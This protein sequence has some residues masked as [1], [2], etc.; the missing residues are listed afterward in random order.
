MIAETAE[1]AVVLK[2]KDQLTG[3][4]TAAE[5][6]LGMLESTASRTATGGLSRLQ[7][8]A[9]GV[10]G[11]LG[12]AKSQLGGLITNLGLFGG[13]A[14]LA[15]IGALVTGSVTKVEAL[16]QA[17]MRLQQVTGESALAT[18]S[19]LAVGEK[20]GVS[21]DSLTGIAQM[22]EKTVGK[23][24]ETQATATKAQKS[25][26]LQALETRKLDIQAAGEKTTLI[27]KLITEQKAQD[28]LAASHGGVVAS[29][30][31]LMAMQ[32][33]FGVVLTDSKGQ[34]IGFTQ[35]LT[36]VSAFYAQATTAAQKAVAADLAASVFGKGYKTLL[37]LLVL[38]KQGFAE[39]TAEAQKFGLTL[40][41][42][43][44]TQFKQLLAVQHTWGDVFGGLQIQAG[45]TIIP[46]LTQIGEA[47]NTFLSDPTN[48]ASLIGALK[49]VEQF[50]EQVGGAFTNV[51]IPA[52]QE[53]GGV[54]NSLP[55]PIKELLIGGFLANK[56]VKWTFGIDIAGLATKALGGAVAGLIGNI[57][58]N[59]TTGVMS[60]EA[61]V[62]NVG[63][64][65]AL[66]AG[67]E[68]A[69]L[70]AAEG[71]AGAGIVGGGLL[72]TIAGVVIPAAAV[73]ALAYFADDIQKFL[74]DN[75]T[76]AST[77]PADQLSWPWGPKNTPHLDIG[78]FKNILGGD[79]SFT[80]PV[81]NSSGGT[82]GPV[83][84]DQYPAKLHA[85]VDTGSAGVMARA[86]AN[87]LHPTITGVAA[88]LA[89]DATTRAIEA[90]VNRTTSAVEGISVAGGT[91]GNVG[92]D[93]Y[94]PVVIHNHV[95]VSARQ[96]ETAA[97]NANAYGPSPSRAGA[98]GAPV[99]T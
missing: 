30:N 6:K 58:K 93:Q 71:E 3:G 63:G 80:T 40:T 39:A 95:T 62:V 5:S 91:G 99:R 78:P 88:T 10:S 9:N 98:Q 83:G 51:V 43:N 66:A 37:P 24:A 29:G 28:A 61:G 72:S 56:A 81:P 92:Q 23:L 96:N 19:L 31:K 2:L 70:P 87:G 18:S 46:M 89:K 4:L 1:L 69:A 57:F 97:T 79:S 82:G 44:M 38:G 73:F 33:Q 85:V 67:A 48:R 11:A 36:N 47:A 64:A 94:T 59:A 76:P 13:A 15:G 21:L 52:I 53:I 90:A 41:D 32:K 45:L 42:Q 54:W 50:A 68:G 16:G 17:T 74:G 77:L 12:H 65:G 34:A 35:A 8:V 7:T 25:A 20:W 60:V 84:S 75:Y 86:I 26:A 49:G 55:G 22:Y 27:N 14:G